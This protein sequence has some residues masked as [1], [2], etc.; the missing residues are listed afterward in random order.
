MRV[1]LYAWVPIGDREK[2]P[3]TQL[4]PVREFVRD[5]NW[6]LH[7]EF[8]EYTPATDIVHGTQWCKLLKDLSKKHFGVL[9]VWWVDRAFR[10][11]PDAVNTLKRF[12]N[13]G[14]DIGASS[15]SWMDREKREE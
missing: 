12:Q 15:D 7:P 14:V 3:V 5:Q 1:G 2:V 4:M 8:I 10:S 11:I 13:W 6:D 9:L